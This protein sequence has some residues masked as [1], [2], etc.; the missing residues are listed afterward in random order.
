MFMRIYLEPCE[1]KQSNC[2]VRAAG[3]YCWRTAQPAMLNINNGQ[4][5]PGFGRRSFP[6]WNTCPKS[7]QRCDGKKRKCKIDAWFLVV[8]SISEKA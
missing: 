7:C 2:A 3:G 1:D 6:L 8:Y 4:I 5:L